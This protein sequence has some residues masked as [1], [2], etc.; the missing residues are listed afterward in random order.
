MPEETD[1]SQA[2]IL[3]VDGEVVARNHAATRLH[4]EGFT[5]L[6]A[7]HGKE[8]LDVLRTYD[9]PIDLLIADMDILKK[10][11]LKLYDQFLQ[12]RPEIKTCAMSA[13]ASDRMQAAEHKVPFLLKPLDPALLRREFADLLTK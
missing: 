7:A 9:G 5:V 8:A 4:R 6:A 1:R 12:E 3:I 13:H 10:D 11:G 2:V